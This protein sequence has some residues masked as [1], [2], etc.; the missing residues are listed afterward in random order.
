MKNQTLDKWN[1]KPWRK[2]VFNGKPILQTPVDL[3]LFTELIQR[4]K[5]A[6]IVEVGMFEGGFTEWL[7]RLA[8]SSD[9][10]MMIAGVDLKVP[11]VMKARGTRFF[12]GDSI[13]QSENVASVVSRIHS[14]SSRPAIIILDDDHDPD[15]VVEEL[16]VYSAMCR[17][18]DWLVVCD[19][20]PVESLEEAVSDWLFRVGQSDGWQNMKL[21]RFGL[22]NNRGG[23][24]KKGKTCSIDT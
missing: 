10:R 9:D 23:W 14:R 20:V 1:G 18:G 21:D 12:Q 13:E 5:P 8:E 19:T 3:W 11:R 6:V 7:L 22:S 17:P 24:L 16:E 15:H 4:I 2:S